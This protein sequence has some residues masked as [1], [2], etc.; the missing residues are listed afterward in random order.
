MRI[1]T[2]GGVKHVTTSKESVSYIMAAVSEKKLPNQKVYVKVLHHEHP[3]H[4]IALLC[5]AIQ[6]V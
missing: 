1:K 4:L 6:Y 3:C 5:G 2:G